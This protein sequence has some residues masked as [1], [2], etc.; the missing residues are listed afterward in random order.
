MYRYDPDRQAVNIQYRKNLAEF[1]AWED[2]K[3]KDQAQAVEAL[4]RRE[5]QAI[6]V[7]QWVA[8]VGGSLAGFVVVFIF[9]T[10]AFS[11]RH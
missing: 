6:K 4:R 3:R 7:P 8:I 9:I 5:K 1:N 11:F 10:L 2:Q